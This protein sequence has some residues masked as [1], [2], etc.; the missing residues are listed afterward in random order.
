[1]I[2][3]PDEQAGQIQAV[4]GMQVE[5]GHYNETRLDD[6]RWISLFAWPGPIHE[7]NGS[8]QVFVDDQASP[9]QREGRRQWS[10]VFS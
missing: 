9:A 2:A 10:T 1:M 8:C 3:A 6:L 7:G 5:H 4:V